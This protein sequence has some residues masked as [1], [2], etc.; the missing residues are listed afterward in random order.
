MALEVGLDSKPKGLITAT[1]MK[2]LLA[3]LAAVALTAYILV[4]AD[5]PSLVDI[6]NKY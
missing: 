5:G 4:L 3:L 6:I 2:L 1:D